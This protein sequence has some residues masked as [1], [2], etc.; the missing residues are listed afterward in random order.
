VTLSNAAVSPNG[1]IWIPVVI[2]SPAAI[3]SFGLDIA[4]P[5]G[6]LQLLGVERT[7]L[8]EDYSQ[9]GANVVPYAREEDDGTGA[10]PEGLLLVRVGGYRNNSDPHPSSGV[11]VTLV[12]RRTGKFHDS[13]ALSIVAGYDGLQNA[14]F[15]SHAPINRR[16]DSRLK[17]TRKES[18][19]AK[20]GPLGQK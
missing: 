15:A 8:T 14:S 10:E 6:V 2:D 19:T 17:D 9:L 18:R 3:D 20:S 12:F 5:A 13:R 16:D 4:F 7:E 11:L 1:D